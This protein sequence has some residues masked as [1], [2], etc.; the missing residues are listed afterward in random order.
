MGRLI[1]RIGKGYERIV[2]GLE[3]LELRPGE[4]IKRQSPAWRMEFIR[5]PGRLTLT[6]QRL[7]FQPTRSYLFPRSGEMY[8]TLEKV[9][10]VETGSLF[11]GLWSA[12]PGV[13]PWRLTSWN[14]AT[15]SFQTSDRDA[16]MAALR[17]EA[18][19]IT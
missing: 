16:W 14:G 18:P 3:D 17:I 1:S 19:H 5:E 7:I 2:M 10:A 13:R 8:I 9:F 15:V 11:A 4:T 12:L 6:N